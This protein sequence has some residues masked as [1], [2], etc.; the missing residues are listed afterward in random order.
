[1]PYYPSPN[2][3]FL[4]PL[5]GAAVQYFQ[6]KDQMQSEQQRRELEQQQMKIAAQQA[7]TEQQLAP[8]EIEL[9]QAKADE[10]KAASQPFPGFPSGLQSA[11]ADPQMP[12]YSPK[13][14]LQ[15]RADGVHKYMAGLYGVKTFYEKRLDWLAGLP[16]TPAVLGEMDSIK[17]HLTNVSTEVENQE[18]ELDRIGEGVQRATDRRDLATQMNAEHLSTAEILKHIPQARI[19]VNTGDRGAAWTRANAD[20]DMVNAAEKAIRTSS[21]PTATAESLAASALEQGAKPRT[22]EAIRALGSEY[23][24]IYQRKHPTRYGQTSTGQGP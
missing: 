17:D 16:Q 23:E 2:Q 24:N 3:G 14:S 9:A 22:I 13:E 5:I 11:P 12:G 21:Y 1:M 10:A 4:A 18:K 8:S 7:A 19:T 6:T 20:P 15:Q